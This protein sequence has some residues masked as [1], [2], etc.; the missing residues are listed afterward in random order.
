MTN[1]PLYLSMTDADLQREIDATKRTLVRA[2]ERGMER[3]V[4]A[5]RC[6]LR[7]LT[8]EGNRRTSAYWSRNNGK[9]N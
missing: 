2:K 3:G 8:L 1:A 4:K 5:C 6:Y 9:R 7:E